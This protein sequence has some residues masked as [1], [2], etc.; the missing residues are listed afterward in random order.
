[1]LQ[2]Y[3]QKQSHQLMTKVQMQDYQLELI[4]MDDFLQNNLDLGF[5]VVPIY[6]KKAIEFFKRRI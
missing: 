5:F 3:Y 1:M 6:P 2:G 4:Y